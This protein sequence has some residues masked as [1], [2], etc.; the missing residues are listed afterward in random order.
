MLLPCAVALAAAAAEQRLP[1]WSQRRRQHQSRSRASEQMMLTL[2]VPEEPVILMHWHS[3]EAR[4]GKRRRG[5]R[6][7]ENTGGEGRSVRTEDTGSMR[8]HTRL[9]LLLCNSTCCFGSRNPLTDCECTSSAA[10]A[11]CLSCLPSL[12]SSFLSL[13]P[14]F[15]D[16]ATPPLLQV[17]SWPVG[18]H[19]F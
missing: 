15:S 4:R 11:T 1:S 9:Y 16:Q 7:W 3:R 12:L 14:S 8:H 10:D 18:F 2:A 5:R 17:C 19:S 6:E 13:S